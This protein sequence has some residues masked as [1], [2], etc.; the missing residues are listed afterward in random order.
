MVWDA[1]SVAT[2]AMRPDATPASTSASTNRKKYAG[3]DPETAVTASIW[4][5]GTVSTPPTDSNSADTALSCSSLAN[6]PGASALTPAPTSMGALG[7][8][9]ITGD[10]AGSF[11]C[12]T[13]STLPRP[14]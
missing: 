11:D 2:A 14:S 7:I 13:W 1:S 5:S 8:T 6:R 9:R 4:L 10:P 12:R 3:P